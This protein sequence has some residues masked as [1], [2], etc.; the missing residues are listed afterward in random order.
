MRI[1]IKKSQ[2]IGSKMHSRQKKKEKKKKEEQSNW[3]LNGPRGLISF[4]ITIL[5]KSLL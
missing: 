3:T 2:N 5:K 4:S 1:K